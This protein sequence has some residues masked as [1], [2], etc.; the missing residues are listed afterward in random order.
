MDRNLE[1]LYE[2]KA[3]KYNKKPTFSFDSKH[4][5]IYKSNHGSFEDEDESY[6]ISAIDLIY[7]KDNAFKDEI[8]IPEP[9]NGIKRND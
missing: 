4:L 1:I 3:D 7:G 6:L 2:F 8:S 9:R 5:F